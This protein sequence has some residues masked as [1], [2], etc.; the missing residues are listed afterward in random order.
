VDISGAHVTWCQQNLSPPFRFV[1]TT[2]FPHL[3]FDDNY[4]GL[5]YAA[6]VF[7]HIS[8]LAEAWLMELR[9]IACPGGRIV[10]TVHDKHSLKLVFDPEWASAHPDANL[11]GH[12]SDGFRLM[13]STPES[14]E[15]LEQD[16]VV[17]TI[18]LGPVSQVFYDAVYLCRHWGRYLKV[19]SI[20][21]E[22]HGYQTAVLLEK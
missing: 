12:V 14:R 20:T 8:D 1:T 11:P 22:A 16:F 9:R 19:H 21:P 10:L 13:L 6:S 4:F 3:P 18:G 15:I 17:A 2:T 5:I 7:T